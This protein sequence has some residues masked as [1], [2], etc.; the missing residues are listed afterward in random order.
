[1]RSGTSFLLSFTALLCCFAPIPTS[2]AQQTS[3]WSQWRGPDRANL[4]SETDLFANWGTRGPK[5]KWMVAGMGSGYASL[6]VVGDTIYTT[7]DSKDAQFC[8]AVSVEDGSVVWSTKLTAERPKHGFE[9]SRCTPTVH[10]GNVYVVSSDGAISCLSAEK[11]DILWSRKFQEWDGK[12]M[13][14]WGF[15]ESPLID[16]ANV[17][18]T[19]GGSQGIVVALDRKTGEDVWA[20]QLPDYGEEFGANGMSLVDGAGYSSVVVSEGGG[21]RQYIQLVGRGLLGIRA[22]D[23]KLL[24]RYARVANGTA[25]IPTTIVDGDFVF[26]STAYNTGSALLKLSSSGDQTGDQTVSA[27]EVYWLDSR[28]FQNKHGG[29]TLFEGHVYCGHGNAA[30]LPI[31]LELATGKIKWGPERTTGKSESALV[32]ADGHIVWRRQSGHVLLTT[33]TPE[34]FE[35]LH[36]FMPAY[37]EGQSWSQPVIAGGVMYLR[38]QDKLMAY[39][40]K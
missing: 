29:M 23:G 24:W 34:K 6:S 32:I 14:S 31:C 18:V 30:G 13:G 4:S 17:I 26:T 38:E 19:P 11:G 27:E 28:T 12:M 15:S 2:L 33:A 22:S 16:G 3:D 39:Q 10:D 35:L 7:G 8:T 20:C 40:L 1:M 9:G 21:V 25:N 36:S 5:L 37:Q